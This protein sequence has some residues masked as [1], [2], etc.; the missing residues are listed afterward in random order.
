MGAAITTTI[1]IV[2]RSTK[3][4]EAGSSQGYTRQ[5][6]LNYRKGTGLLPEDPTPCCCWVEGNE[7]GKAKLFVAGRPFLKSV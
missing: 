5:T 7:D 3:R 6:T 4:K 1:V 2:P